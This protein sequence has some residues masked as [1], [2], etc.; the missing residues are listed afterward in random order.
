MQLPNNYIFI[1]DILKVFNKQNANAYKYTHTYILEASC[2]NCAL[3]SYLLGIIC[4]ICCDLCIISHMASACS[5][6]TKT[7]LLLRSQRS[8][9]WFDGTRRVCERLHLWVCICTSTLINV[10]CVPLTDNV[11]FHCWQCDEDR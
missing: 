5:F 6:V 1:T 8:F 9:D 11:I 4:E 7:R 2:R 10:R 3:Q